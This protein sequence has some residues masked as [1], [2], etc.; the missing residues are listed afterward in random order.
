MPAEWE[1]A[2]NRLRRRLTGLSFALLRGL[3][4]Q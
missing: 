1:N 3:P 2:P 4:L